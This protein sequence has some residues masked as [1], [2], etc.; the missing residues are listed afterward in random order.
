MTASWAVIWRG[1]NC[2]TYMTKEGGWT[3]DPTE[4]TSFSS[5]VHARVAAGI[6]RGVSVVRQW[7]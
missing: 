1:K 4:A 2:V 6:T 7:T 3:L 5:W